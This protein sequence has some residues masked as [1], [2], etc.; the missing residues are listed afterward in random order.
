[1]KGNAIWFLVG[2]V[3]FILIAALT[4]SLYSHSN[5]AGSI[6]QGSFSTVTAK[7]S[8]ELKIVSWNLHRGEHLDDIIA[9]LKNSDELQD[10]DFI[11]VQEIDAKGIQALA[12]SLEYNYAFSPAV[13][14]REH[15]DEFGVGIL[16]KWS[17]SDAKT[18]RLPNW[19]PRLAEE[20]NAI[21]ATATNGDRTLIVYS[22]HTDVIR[23]EPQAKFLA[24]EAGSQDNKII[25]GGD[26]N[27]W[28][29]SSIDALESTMQEI[30]LERL[31]TNAG[32]TFVNFG[33]PFTLDHIFSSTVKDYSSGVYYDTDASDHFPLWAV[34]KLPSQE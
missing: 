8:S 25:V 34:I 29:K 20:R 2:I 9:T 21:K 5:P 16:S 13:Y 7:D 4:R 19:L 17:L 18:V 6:E 31:S 3:V 32:N 23:M 1:L 11:L 10:A 28:R 27:T 30:G 22:V 15:D 33:V 12:M 24:E 26:F 14:S